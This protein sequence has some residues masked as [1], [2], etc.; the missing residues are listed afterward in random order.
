MAAIA[1]IHEAVLDEKLTELEK[2][3]QWS[4]RVISKLETFIR[5]GDDYDLFR[6][7]PIQ[8]AADRG[9]SEQ[10]AID[11]FLYGV[12]AGLF[13]MEWHLI[14]KMCGQVV[15]NFRSMDRLHGHFTCTFCS[16]ENEAHLDDY[17][18]VAFT[19]SRHI[20]DLIYHHP[21][22]LT[23]EDFFLKYSVSKGIQP[24]QGMPYFQVM[25]ELTKLTTYVEAGTTE[26]V[27]FEASPG[28][29]YG[30]DLINKTRCMILFSDPPANEVQRLSVTLVD[31]RLLGV[32][33]DLVPQRLD[34]GPVVFDTTN[35]GTIPAGRIHFEVTNNMST[36]GSMWLFHV[37]TPLLQ[38]KGSNEYD[39]F[40]SGKRL[41]SNQTFRDLFRSEV[42]R[43]EEGLGVRDIT[44][45]FT[46]LKGS[47]ALYDQIGDAKA[48][49]LVR[50]HFDTLGRVIAQ[51][52]GAVVKTIGDAVMATFVEPRDATAA[53]LEMLTEIE[54]FNAGISEQ[55]ILK[56]GIHRGHS[57]VVTLNDRLDYFG[58]TVNI[59]S[60]VQNLAAASEIVITDRIKE[61]GGIDDLLDTCV[62]VIPEETTLRGIG[63]KMQVYRLTSG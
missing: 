33:P 23:P 20:R 44:F 26:T 46:D 53:A 19:L 9:M 47:T 27:E 32:D 17:I 50:Q 28:L 1:N 39:P 58:Q 48:Y 36:R 22:Q 40:L 43:S 59:A 30:A 12:K 45:M 42:V 37:P 5:T 2:A 8:Y 52:N 55:L 60:R 61:A 25:K 7:N 4:P 63:E 3:R 35:S 24:F 62:S 16:V 41:L 6:I 56:I 49:Y 14:C 10:E 21:D 11:L 51:H 29:M 31:G 15:D 34:F 54:K 57:I 13:E 18:Q 38:A